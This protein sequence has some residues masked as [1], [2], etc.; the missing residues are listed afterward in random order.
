MFAHKDNVDLYNQK[1]TLG[2]TMT[3]AIQER[4]RGPAIVVKDFHN[5]IKRALI[6][7]FCTNADRLYDIG[8]G[9]GGDIAKWLEANIHFVKG[10][11]PSPYSIQE[12]KERFWNVT[13][14]T[15]SSSAQLQFQVVKD[16]GQRDYEEPQ[17]FQ[18]ASAMFSLHYFFDSEQSAQ[19]L[20]RNVSRLLVPGGVFFGCFPAGKRILMALD[21][22]QEH[23]S[24]F[25]HITRPFQGPP[26]CFGSG[27]TFALRDT[28]TCTD[29]DDDKQASREYLVFFNVVLSLADQVGLEPIT[30]YGEFRATSNKPHLAPFQ[31]WDALFEK[32]DRNAV[33]KHFSP[34]HFVHVDPSL[35]MASRL[36]CAFAFRKK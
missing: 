19:Q 11:D 14:R 35:D 29:N 33:F 32:N 36:F 27:Y 23:T 34:N 16:F 6:L 4:E 30:D 15:P 18:C 2:K 9:R 12:C 1:A 31:S 28:V 26:Q 25:L 7:Q 22:A 24:A 13:K 3:R 20:F 21:G 10:I 17:P 8:C 5:A